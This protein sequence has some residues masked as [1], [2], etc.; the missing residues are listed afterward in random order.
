MDGIF[1]Y[2]AVQYMDL[3]KYVAESRRVLKHGG[4]AL[5]IGHD[6]HDME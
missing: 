6:F 4:L 3:E 5:S 1:S 2:F